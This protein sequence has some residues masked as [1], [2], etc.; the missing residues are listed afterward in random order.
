MD[1]PYV[2]LALMK[3]TVQNGKQEKLHPFDFLSNTY[4]QNY[5]P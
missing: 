5:P 1:N 4:D 2:E 3:L